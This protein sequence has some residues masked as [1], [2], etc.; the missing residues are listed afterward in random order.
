MS[1]DENYRPI[2]RYIQMFAGIVMWGWLLYT[3][4][5]STVDFVDLSAAQV[6]FVM[7][8]YAFAAVLIKGVTAKEIAEFI[9]AWRGK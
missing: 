5:K 8:Q 9:R 4:S 3:D 1:D 6:T 7:G 2:E